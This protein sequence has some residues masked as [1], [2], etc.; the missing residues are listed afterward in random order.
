MAH[1]G[2]NVDMQVHTSRDSFSWRSRSPRAASAVGRGTWC[3]SARLA[4]ER[5]RTGRRTHPGDRLGHPAR[6]GRGPGTCAPA[7][8]RAPPARQFP[9]ELPSQPFSTNFWEAGDPWAAGGRPRRAGSRPERAKRGGSRCG[10]AGA[11]LEAAG[12]SSSPAWRL[13]RPW[14]HLRRLLRRCATRAA[15][16]RARACWA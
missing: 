6:T 5:A 4:R 11:C 2:R 12:G 15:A 3:S 10:G 1:V 9:G 14:Q 8:P 16:A 13:P 7:V